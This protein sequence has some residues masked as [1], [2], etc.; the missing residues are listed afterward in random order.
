MYM[1]VPNEIRN[2]FGFAG[3]QDRALT[4]LLK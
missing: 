4:D 1:Y 2:A 3:F